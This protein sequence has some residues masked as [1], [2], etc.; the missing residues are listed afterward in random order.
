MQVCGQEFTPALIA[1]IEER[2]RAVPS[3]SR[4]ALSREVCQWLDWR[5]RLGR[6]KEM[7][8]RAAMRR[9]ERTGRLRLPAPVHRVAHGAWRGAPARP[10]DAGEAISPTLSMSLQA[11]GKVELVLVAGAR[12]ANGQMWRALMEQHHPL[13]AGP[14]CGAQL[15]YLIVSPTHGPLGALA[16]CSAAWRVRV[17]DEHIGWSEA[18]RAARLAEVV[19]N[20]RFLIAPGVR[21]AHLASHVLALAT[22]RLRADWAAQYGYAPVLVETYVERERHRGTC[23]RAAN[24][25]CIGPTTGRG[26]Q[27]R[28][29]CAEL[30]VKDLYLYPLLRNWRARLCAPV[31][32]APQRVYG[33]DWAH[34]EFSRVALGDARLDA[35]VLSMARD[36]YARPQAQLPGACANPAKTKAAY[37]LL[38]HKR[39][40][41]DAL[42]ASH[43]EASAARVAEHPV[44]LAVQDSTSLNYTAHPLTEGLGPLNT[45]RDSALG[46]WMHD[47]L[48]FTPEGTPLGL[49]D[50]QCWAR[51]PARTAKASRYERP[52]EQ[53]ESAKWLHSFE[54]LC[55]LQARCPHTTL[56]SVGDREADVY[57]LLVR[58]QRPGAAKLLIRAER[59]RRMVQDHGSLW[60][61]M[62]SPAVPLAATQ[63]LDVPPRHNRP[64]RS[65]RLEIRFAPV[66]LRA[67]K[68]KSHLPSVRL[69]AV[70]AHE[71]D[72][73]PGVAALDW[74]VLTTVAVHTLE[75]AL[76]RVHWY[77]QRWGIEVYHRTL[78]SGCRIEQR[79]LGSAERLE[80][81]LAF[82]L[83]VAWRIYYLTKLGRET[84]DVPC[85][86]YFEDAQWKAL[87]TI[88]H[89]DGR[90]P[91]HGPPSLNAAMCMVATLGGFLGRKSDGHP[92][93]K[94]LW[95][96]LQRLDDI[97]LGM[98]AVIAAIERGEITVSRKH[99]YG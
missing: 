90:A 3:L 74:M 27:D 10:P 59:T 44:V 37:R 80:T 82:D 84:P 64:R 8:A 21:I 52:I 58:A 36:L 45:S 61:Y 97:T 92:G 67:P 93:P 62:A 35:R 30:P 4:R 73:P 29:R 15:R 17:R 89:R 22:R 1:R 72:P 12:S 19:C 85:T 54:T 60:H 63:I 83:V 2:A 75:D 56:V 33:G 91:Q 94:T 95:L 18:A 6:P 32:L 13:G 20:T 42:L 66:T 49:L 16:F 28:D 43:Y 77:R 7:S 71:P 48:A 81:C 24:W 39:V 69:W 86:V 41:R 50:V 47:T 79:Q 51:D 65:A 23:Y 78:K 26:R 5:D 14:L 70:W 11:L 40:S 57:E 31:L 38:D 25:Q 88:M 46:L 53:K 98:T 34:E 55:T 99:D 76:E 9:L 68:R 96:G 87:V